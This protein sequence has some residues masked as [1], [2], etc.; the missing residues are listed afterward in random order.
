MSKLF[1][2]G[3]ACAVVVLVAVVAWILHSHSG[4]YLEP[5]GKMLQVRTVAL[6]PASSALVIDFEVT[7]PS[8]RDMVVRF[9][10]VKVTEPDGSIPDN[11]MIAATDLPAMFRYHTELG[12]LNLTPMR[13]RDHI[14]PGR[15][16]QRVTAVRYDLTE[17]QLKQRK[18]VELDIVDVTGP[19]LELAAK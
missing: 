4:N 16:V 17:E 1:A 6:D 19:K 13:E 9:I 10:N 14:S 3:F 18:A 5:T 8:G 15:T 2:I 7:N 12:A 11:S